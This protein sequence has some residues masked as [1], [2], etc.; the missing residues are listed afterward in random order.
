MGR[1]VVGG[2]CALVLIPAFLLAQ[3]DD[4]RA[5]I[6]ADVMADP[7]SAQMSESEIDALV[8]AIAVEAD[9]AGITAE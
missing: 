8:E 7:R 3:S 6:R 9:N 1:A 2:L 5:Q 4:L